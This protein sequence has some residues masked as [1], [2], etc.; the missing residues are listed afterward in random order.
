MGAPAPRR[1]TETETAFEE[2]SENPPLPRVTVDP[3]VWFSVMVPAPLFTWR[4]A[5]EKLVSTVDVNGLD[6]LLL[7]IAVTP[8]AGSPK[9]QLLE[10]FQF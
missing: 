10:L 1:F 9:S 2:E 5:T 3:P 8:L 6:V 7:K 4:A